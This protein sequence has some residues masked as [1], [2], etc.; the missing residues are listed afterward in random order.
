MMRLRRLRGSI[1]ARDD[2]M[3]A[4]APGG[5]FTSFSESTDKFEK[6]KERATSFSERSLMQDADL[7]G[8]ISSC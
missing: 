7:R 5:I 6:S 2:K 8:D 4:A 1:P 3:D